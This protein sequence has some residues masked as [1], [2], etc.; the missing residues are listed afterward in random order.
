MSL[1]HEKQVGEISLREKQAL[2]EIENL[3]ENLKK[4]VEDNSKEMLSKTQQSKQKILD[5]EAKI[6][7]L[8]NE[9]SLMLFKQEKMKTNWSIEKDH[10]MSAKTELLEKLERLRKQ[11]EQANRETDKLKSELRF[12]R[13]NTLSSSYMNIGSGKGGTNHN[14]SGMKDITAM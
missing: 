10:L 1:Y 7:A 4:T 13:K 2:K 14:E 6:R 11:N 12:A 5:Q 9:K 8:E 3:K